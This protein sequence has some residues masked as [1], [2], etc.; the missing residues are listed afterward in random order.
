LL[1]LGSGLLFAVAAIG[2]FH[3]VQSTKAGATFGTML[4]I[5]TAV[6]IVTAGITKSIFNLQIST[7]FW[8]FPFYLV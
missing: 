5:Q 2:V 8:N 3:L 4:T 1:K 6:T 7:N